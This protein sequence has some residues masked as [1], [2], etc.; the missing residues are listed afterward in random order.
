VDTGYVHR[1]EDFTWV[2]GAQEAVRLLNT[3]GYLVFVVT[4]QSGVARGLYDCDAV[5][6]LH[7]WM[8]EDLKASGAHLDAVRYCPHHPQGAVARFARRCDCRK[9]QPGMLLDLAGEW[10][11]DLEASFILGDSQRDL[12]AGRR[13][14][15]DGHRVRDG[16]TL[17]VVRRLLDAKRR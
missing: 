11:V 12:E 9:P 14:G 7:R 10:Q 13:A 8:L 4:N 2:E 17:A 3:A 1:V 6:T 5:D 16:D 15:I